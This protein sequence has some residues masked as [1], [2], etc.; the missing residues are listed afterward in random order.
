MFSQPL[1][2]MGHEQSR[3][4]R[5]NHIDVD[6]AS[7]MQ[8]EKDEGWP[9]GTWVK[10]FLK[11]NETKF[12]RKWGC[13]TLNKYDYNSITHY[14]SRLGQVNP[15]TIIRNKLPCGEEGCHFGQRWSLS[16][17]DVADLEKQYQCSK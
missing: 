5:D 16:S 15:R 1:L 9:N 6:F 7:I 14:P 17:L 4:D 8:F 2:G 10:Q 3:P 11:C 12:G 13:K